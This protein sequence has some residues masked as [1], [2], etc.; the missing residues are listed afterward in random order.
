VGGGLFVLALL[1][2][3]GGERAEAIGGY[4]NGCLVNGVQVA[5]SGPGFETIRRHRRRYF[6][7]PRLRAFITDFGSRLLK[8]GLAPVLVG[9]T[10]QAGGGRMPSG[11]RSHQTGLDADFWF[12]RP[13]TRDRDARFGRLVD[14]AKETID[15]TAWTDAHPRMLKLAAQSPDVARVFVHWV[16]KREL[17]RTTS[18]PRDWLRKIRPWWGHD[19]HFH[20]RLRCPEGSGDC[21]NQPDP[22]TDECGQEAWFSK[23]SVAKRKKVG[24]KGRKRKPKPL[25]PRCVAR[26]RRK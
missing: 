24:K 23:A 5:P 7:H 13:K 2:A 11:H 17:C 19:R 12:T 16:I 9:D 22:E 18:A 21:R 4:G 14:R 1:L 26:K 25:H 3:P 10:A 15:D 6:A 8:A 20:V